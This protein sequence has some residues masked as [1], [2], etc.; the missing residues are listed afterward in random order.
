M[1]SLHPIWIFAPVLTL[2][3][4]LF[5]GS[6]LAKEQRGTLDAHKNNFGPRKLC[7]DVSKDSKYISEI[8]LGNV[9]V[10]WYF[11]ELLREPMK[12]FNVTWFLPKRAEKFHPGII[13][14]GKGED[15]GFTQLDPAANE[16]PR[17]LD[18]IAKLRP[19]NIKMYG[20]VNVTPPNVFGANARSEQNQHAGLPG[21]A[22]QGRFFVPI[23]P[24][25]LG[26]PGDDSY[27]VKGSP[28]WNRLFVQ[29]FVSPCWDGDFVLEGEA[30]AVLRHLKGF[31]LDRLDICRVSF[32]GLW[33]IDQAL[34]ESCFAY[35]AGSE[36]RT[37]CELKCAPGQ[38]P[39]AD[40]L[41]CEAEKLPEKPVSEAAKALEDELMKAAGITPE[42]TETSE[43]GSEEKGATEPLENLEASLIEAAGLDKQSQ[44]SR[45][46]EAEQASSHF[47][48]SK[49]Q[50]E[51]KQ[52]ERAAE[53][54]ALNARLN[55][56]RGECSEDSPKAPDRPYRRLYLTSGDCDSDCRARQ[57]R[58]QERAY[59]RRVDEYHEEREDYERDY[60]RWERRRD[61]CLAQAEEKHQARLRDLAAKHEADNRRLEE[62]QRLERQLMGQ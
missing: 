15:G 26:A 20:K 32:G 7:F 60:A 43:L 58:N 55:E 17:I 14:T 49:A 27:H 45:A 28:S 34:K 9:V 16:D 5:S 11:D 54:D 3:L 41:S 13:L 22:T 29:S 31:T 62:I 59:Q 46:D 38:K 36:A 21:N 33:E 2:A 12:D 8:C 6:A 39:S 25:A 56:A 42:G 10:N 53:R 35:A 48:L 61:Q 44:R 4:L 30:K 47:G 19:I 40:G 50:W 23:D 52:R 1:D 18:A 37:R 24:G 57:S 51:K